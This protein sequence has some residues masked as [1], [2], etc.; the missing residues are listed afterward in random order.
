M[1]MHATVHTSTPYAHAQAPQK[2]TLPHPDVRTGDLWPLFDT[3]NVPG[4]SSHIWLQLIRICCPDLQLQAVALRGK[5]SWRSHCSS[6]WLA[7]QLDSWF[8]DWLKSFWCSVQQR[9]VNSEHKFSLKIRVLLAVPNVCPN[10]LNTQKT[11]MLAHMYECYTQWIQTHTCAG[12]HTKAGGSGK[13]RS[14]LLIKQKA[15]AGKRCQIDCSSV[16]WDHLSI[17]VVKTSCLVP[18]SIP[19]SLHWACGHLKN[20]DARRVW[21]LRLHTGRYQWFAPAA[22]FR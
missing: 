3:K 21:D 15:R 7:V 11:L 16:S 9:K 13:R 19:S 17:T 14:W 1:C 8:S 10:M 20:P 2:G 5:E 12:M 18:Q 22:P 4:F 6:I